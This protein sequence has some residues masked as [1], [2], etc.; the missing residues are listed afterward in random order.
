[1]GLMTSMRG[2]AVQSKDP[3]NWYGIAR[4]N[5][6]QPPFNNRK[7][8][9]AVLAAVRQED[10]MGAAFGDDPSVW[11]SCRAM[12]PCG[13]PDVAEIGQAAM[14]GLPLDAARKAV[15]ESGYAGERTVVAARQSA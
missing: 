11:Q 5:L 6:L 9:R 8:R 7:L 12:M 1:M 4:F 13:V 15:A 14:P 2:V 10:Y 3:Y